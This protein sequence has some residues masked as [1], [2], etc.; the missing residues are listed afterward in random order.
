MEG[1]MLGRTSIQAIMGISAAQ[2]QAF[3]TAGVAFFDV[4]RWAEAE[5]IF[6]G[7]ALLQP[8]EQHWRALGAVLQA[9]GK[10]AAAIGAY[11]Q[12][13]KLGKVPAAD[14]EQGNAVDQIKPRRSGELTPAIKAQ[15]K[16]CRKHLKGKEL[17]MQEEV[18]L[19]SPFI[20]DQGYP[21]N[22]EQIEALTQDA[23]QQ[24]HGTLKALLTNAQKLVDETKRGE[25][26]EYRARK[27]N[28]EKQS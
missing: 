23:V 15:I 11:S 14:I 27:H 26:D 1:L 10:Y 8:S 25:W 13:K 20:W 24:F 12:V 18:E 4:G 22:E 21:R 6:R 17:S 28:K 16:M 9:Q 5:A 2:I 3:Y 7:L 19:S